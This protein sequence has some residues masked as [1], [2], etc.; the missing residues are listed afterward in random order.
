V[1]RVV[2]MV[3][4]FLLKTSAMRTTG[5]SACVTTVHLVVTF[6]YVSVTSPEPVAASFAKNTHKQY[7]VGRFHAHLVYWLCMIGRQTSAVSGPSGIPIWT[8]F[9]HIIAFRIDSFGYL[10][11][12]FLFAWCL[13]IQCCS[14]VSWWHLPLHSASWSVYYSC[15]ARY[16]P[17]D[18]S[19]CQ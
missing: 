12:M 8:V 19:L 13:G 1:C 10:L 11:E 17:L 6:I 4:N 7:S 9:D 2:L 14:D 15:V 3:L 18:H 16:Q 5:R